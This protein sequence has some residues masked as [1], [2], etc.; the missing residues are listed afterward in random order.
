MR[1]AIC[2][3]E[4][5]FIEQFESVVYSVY[6]RLDIDLNKYNEALD[7]I[8]KALEHDPN[9]YRLLQNKISVMEAM[10]GKQK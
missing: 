6:N 3:D 2:D 4:K 9:N 7:N 8:N 1:F 5:I 10:Y